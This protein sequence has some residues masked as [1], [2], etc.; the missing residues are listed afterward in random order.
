M[1]NCADIP[2]I[3]R[4]GFYIDNLTFHEYKEDQDELFNKPNAYKKIM[5]YIDQYISIYKKGENAAT[6]KFGFNDFIKF[7]DYFVKTDE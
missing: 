2:L 4:V 7:V 1:V 5:S 6:A 3:M